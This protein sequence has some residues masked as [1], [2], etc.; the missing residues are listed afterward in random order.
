MKQLIVIAGGGGTLGRAVAGELIARGLRVV[1]VDLAAADL[2]AGAEFE[3]ADLT[4]DEDVSRAYRKIANDHGSPAGI[5]NVVGGF[6][7]EPMA[8]G[9]TATWDAMYRINLKTVAASCQAALALLDD[10]SSIVNVGAAAARHP[11]SGMAPYS[12]SKA[13]VHALTESLAEEL[14]SRLI[15]VNAVLPTI[16]DTPANRAAMRDADPSG[17]VSPARAAK[18]IAFLLSDDASAVTGACIPLSS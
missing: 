5:V 3:E 13:G 17:W 1:I 15:R 16:I 14:R 12:A 18:A 9:S 2:P 7:F 6:A 4:S 10:G 8:E 11:G